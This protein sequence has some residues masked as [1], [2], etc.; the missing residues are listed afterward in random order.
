MS[1]GIVVLVAVALLLLGGITATSAAFAESGEQT[2]IS[3]ENFT[4]QAG[5]VTTLSDSNV[6]T[7]I[8]DD[9]V[10]VLDENESRVIAGEDFV[11]Y[12]SNGTIKTVAGGRLD[13]DT[14]ASITYGYSE[15]SDSSRNIAALLGYGFD[16]ASFTII[17]LGVGLVFGAVAVLGRLS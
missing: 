7:A 9:D 16:A 4:P 12:D 17:A 6:P 15:P 3:G 11:W 8:Y 13:G 1:K 14:S 2:E 5:T 10:K